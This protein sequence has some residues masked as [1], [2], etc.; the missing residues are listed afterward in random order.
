MLAAQ[1]ISQPLP[2]DYATLS[3]RK[4]ADIIIARSCD[5]SNSQ[6]TSAADAPSEAAASDPAAS[7]PE[8]TNAS[9]NAD[10]S[11]TSA[12][13]SVRAVGPSTDEVSDDDLS[14]SE[15]EEEEEEVEPHNEEKDS[16]QRPGRN[17][18]YKKGSA[19]PTASYITA[20]KQTLQ[21]RLLGTDQQH[22]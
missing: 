15:E 11:E 8:R 18:V 4:G 5:K 16:E 21:F 22:W 10:S 9:T 6:H 13:R 2:A 20:S 3:H 17:H 7:E 19:E 12:E 14:A 1:L